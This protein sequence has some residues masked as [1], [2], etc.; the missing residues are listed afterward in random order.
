MPPWCVIVYGGGLVL[1]GIECQLQCALS[2]DV[3]RYYVDGC[4]DI[5]W[6]EWFHCYDLGT[7]L[8]PVIKK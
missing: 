3:C 4:T 8:G 6:E 1:H 2:I 7:Q 5:L